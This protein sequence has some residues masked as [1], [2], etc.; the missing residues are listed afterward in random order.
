M[1]NAPRKTELL[2]ITLGLLILSAAQI[3]NHF[4]TLADGF[5]GLLTGFGIGTMLLFFI[6][7]RKH[8]L[9]AIRNRKN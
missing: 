7:R 1:K 8:Q 5:L 6:L 3:L 9:V 2:Y 4:Y